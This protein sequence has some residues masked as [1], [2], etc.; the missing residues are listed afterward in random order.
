ML[1][2]ATRNLKHLG[3]TNLQLQLMRL[4]LFVF[5]QSKPVEDFYRRGGKLLDFEVSGGIP[6]TWPRL[7]AALNV[8]EKGHTNHDD[9]HKF[10]A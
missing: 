9:S 1:V 2:S 3:A 6:E 8:D 4:I 7:L 10:A 5:L